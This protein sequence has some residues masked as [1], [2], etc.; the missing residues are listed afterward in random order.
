MAVLFAG[1]LIGMMALLNNSLDTDAYA[2]ALSKQEEE[3]GANSFGTAPGGRRKFTPFG[4]LSDIIYSPMFPS[5]RT[6]FV[7]NSTAFGNYGYA[8]NQ[9]GTMDGLRYEVYQGTEH[10]LLI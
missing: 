2:L 4:R 1:G 7:T 9:F 3:A 6:P 8:K 5:D 10:N